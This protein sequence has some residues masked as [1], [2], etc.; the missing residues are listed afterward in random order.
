[1]IWLEEVGGQKGYMSELLD[2]TEHLASLG[3]W[4]ALIFT[5]QTQN[6]EEN[7]YQRQRHP[8]AFSDSS[9]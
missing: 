9:R 7:T 4:M 8:L 2:I 3:T 5:E 6:I 1:M